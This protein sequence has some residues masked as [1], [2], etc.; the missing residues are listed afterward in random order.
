[1]LGHIVTALQAYLAAER[2]TPGE[3]QRRL[4]LPRKATTVYSWLG[5][6]T[7]PGQAFKAQLSQ[8][9]GQP[10]S[11]FYPRH[12]D[13]PSVPALGPA[14]TALALAAQLPAPPPP[15]PPAG[16]RLAYEG[17]GDGTASITLR[18]RLPLEQAKP[19]FRLLLDAGIDM[20][21]DTPQSGASP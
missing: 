3:L 21:T 20:A 9:L 2:I 8:L 19:L 4:G 1:V 7:C 12:E 16:G 17:H 11:F 15:G 14:R 13:A 10:V 5:G 18:A 6:R